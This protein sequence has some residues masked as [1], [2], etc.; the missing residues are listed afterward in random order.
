MYVVYILKSLKN[1]HYYIGNTKDLNRRL[2]RH[3][4]GLEKYTKKFIPYKLVYFEKY[5]S[6]TDAI[7]REKQIKSYKKGNAFK[8][9][10]IDSSRR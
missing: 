7:I 5:N 1:G 10:L 4:R 3:N 9:L 6:I 8:K 2:E